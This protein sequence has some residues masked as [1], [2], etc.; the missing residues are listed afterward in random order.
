MVASQSFLAVAAD[1]SVRLW[2]ES[3]TL[4]VA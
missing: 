1:A 3:L 4:A 2:L